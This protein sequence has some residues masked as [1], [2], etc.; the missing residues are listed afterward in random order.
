YDAALLAGLLEQLPQDF[1]Y[2][3]QN[4]ADYSMAADQSQ[5]GNLFSSWNYTRANSTYRPRSSLTDLTNALAYDPALKTLVLHGYTDLRTPF[6]QSELDLKG[7][8]LQDR[9][10]V[11]LYEGGH[12]T[13][14][15]Q[16]S[17][18]LL[19]SDLDAFY[20]A[21]PYGSPPVVATQ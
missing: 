7:I 3:V 15:T 12:M 10:P 21:P 5:P 16:P 14:F 6:H 4:G 1:D 18:Q 8:G 17:R 20:D 11:K 9:V 13:Y 2:H 19:K